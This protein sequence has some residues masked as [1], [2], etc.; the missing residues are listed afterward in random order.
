MFFKKDLKKSKETLYS[1]LSSSWCVVPHPLTVCNLCLLLLLLCYADFFL[2][3]YNC[4]C[5]GVKICTWFGYNPQ[6]YFITVS[7]FYTVSFLS[8]SDTIK[9][10]ISG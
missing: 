9:V 1:A 6:A 4:F 8:G 10:Y 5:H 7:A 2:K 3:L